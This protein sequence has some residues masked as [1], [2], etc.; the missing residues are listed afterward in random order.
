MQN[1]LRTIHGFETRS[2]TRFRLSAIGIEIT[3]GFEAPLKT[4]TEEFLVKYWSIVENMF[5]IISHPY[6]VNA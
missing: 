2:E 3:T 4:P 1:S 6:P 5:K